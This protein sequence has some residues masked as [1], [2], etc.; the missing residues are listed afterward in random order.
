[1]RQTIRRARLSAAIILTI[2]AAF[3]LSFISGTDGLDSATATA[4][5]AGTLTVVIDA[6]HGGADGGAVS[7]SGV[8]ESEIN[9]DIAERLDTILGFFGTRVVMTRTTEDLVY[10]ESADTIREKKVEDQKKRLAL[11]KNTENAVLLSIHQNT[12]PSGGPVGAQVLYAPTDGSKAFATV[13]QRLMKDVLNK[14]SRRTEARAP[15]SILLMNHITCPALLIEC[16]FLSNAAEERLLLTEVYRLK[17]AAVIAAGYLQHRE[18]LSNICNGGLYE[19][20]DSVL[21]Y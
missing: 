20:K 19:G 5:G 8:R 3:F 18:T 13:M 7:L 21:L 1:M 16:G 15:D 10:S 9:L 11:I 12:Y 17:V 14:E 2:G 6:G 4:T